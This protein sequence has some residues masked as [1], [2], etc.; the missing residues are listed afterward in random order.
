MAKE[1]RLLL[2]HFGATCLLLVPV[3][4]D[5]DRTCTPLVKEKGP[6]PEGTCGMRLTNLVHTI[7]EM[8]SG[9]KKRSYDSDTT[10]I[11]GIGP[12]FTLPGERSMDKKSALDFLSKRTPYEEKGIVCEC[13]YHRCSFTELAQYCMPGGGFLI[14]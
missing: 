3:F 12:P 1:G 13:C 6:H 11:Q 14:R 2:H 4:C 7:C 9:F 8:F 10:A 5:L